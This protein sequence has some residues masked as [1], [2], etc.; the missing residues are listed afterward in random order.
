MTERAT[1]DIA[2]WTDES[3]RGVLSF[4]FDDVGPKGWFGGGPE[5]DR[6]ITERYAALHGVVR[7][8]ADEHLLGN[9][10]KALA[11]VLVLD[12]FSRQ[13]YRGSAEAF[14]SD[15]KAV[16]L[17][18]AALARKFD[19]AVLPARR[20]FFYLP[21][22]HAEDLAL[23]DRAVA[24]ISQLGDETY[25]RYAIAHRDVIARFGRFPHRN[26]A[27]GRRSTEVERAYLAQ[28]GSG[29]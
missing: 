14:A 22:E 3:A 9:A 4:W 24:L 28:P 19:A 13:I 21:F 25:T 8:T 5:L 16:T 7:A 2:A 29:F 11:A 27:L 6:A 20:I 18:T 23:Q 26:A 12:Q 1:S 15:A 10:D 17:A